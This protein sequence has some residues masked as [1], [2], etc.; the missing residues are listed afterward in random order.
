VLSEIV[1]IVLKLTGASGFRRFD[2]VEGAVRIL[3]GQE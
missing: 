2:S 1:G 3:K